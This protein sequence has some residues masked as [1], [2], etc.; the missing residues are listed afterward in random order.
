MRA[1]LLTVAFALAISVLINV[2]WF[3]L[4]LYRL[5][6]DP[7]ADAVAVSISWKELAIRVSSVALV[8]LLLLVTVR[9]LRT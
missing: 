6:H 4:R 1:N 2:A 3:G 8:V 5:F 7:T 9:W